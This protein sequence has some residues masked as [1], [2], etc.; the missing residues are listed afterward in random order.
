MT[1]HIVLGLDPLVARW[2]QERIPGA[3]DFG[4]C[5]AVG[6]A[7]GDLLIAGAVYNNFHGHMIEGS[8]ASISPKWC[9]KTTIRAFLAYP[10]LQLKVGRLQSTVAKKNKHTRR[11]LERLGFRLEGVGRQAWPDG[12]DACVY[13]MLRHE[14]EKWLKQ[15]DKSVE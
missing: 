10:F 4:K 2:V 7:D 13:S 15:K 6:I 8:I 3:R 14:A 11:F 12:S 1:V 5:T 9:N